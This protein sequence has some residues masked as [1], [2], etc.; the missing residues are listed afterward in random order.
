M[1]IG[2]D[3]RACAVRRGQSVARIAKA[4]RDAARNKQPVGKRDWR[5]RID[6]VSI[7]FAMPTHTM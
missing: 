6:G 1:V 7:R 2:G 3:E 5:E 4:I